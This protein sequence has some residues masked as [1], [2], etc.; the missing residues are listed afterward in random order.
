MAHSLSG[1]GVLFG[2]EFDAVVLVDHF[3]QNEK[4]EGD[5]R[6]LK[7]INTVRPKQLMCQ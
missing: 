3:A 4:L 6:S 1:A 7:Y 5:N 2:E